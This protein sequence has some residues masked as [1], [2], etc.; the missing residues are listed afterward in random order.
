MR[1][2]VFGPGAVGGTIAGRL[3]QHGHDVTVIGRGAHLDVIRQRGLRVVDPGATF[4]ATLHAVAAVTAAPYAV[5]LD[6]VG[7]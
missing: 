6:G 2:V 4:D 3:A 1:Y 7:V 5:D